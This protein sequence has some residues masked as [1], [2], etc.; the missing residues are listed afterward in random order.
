MFRSF[1]LVAAMAGG[2]LRFRL[3]S[4]CLLMLVDVSHVLMA[5]CA[6]V[7]CMGG[8]QEFLFI[9]LLAMAT[10]AIAVGNEPL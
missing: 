6:G 7:G 3:G 5:A 9:D 1:L 10:Q 4:P 2:R 8:S